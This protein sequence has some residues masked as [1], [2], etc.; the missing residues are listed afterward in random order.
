MSASVRLFASGSASMLRTRKAAATFARS[1]PSAGPY[2]LTHGA[3]LAGKP[4]PATGP[5]DPSGVVDPSGATDAPSSPFRDPPSSPERGLAG[6]APA[7]D[8]VEPGGGRRS[9]SGL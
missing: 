1:T 5:L 6:A 2:Q 8:A 7:S 3:A 4:R 9:S